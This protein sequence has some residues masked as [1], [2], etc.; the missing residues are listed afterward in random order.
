MTYLKLNLTYNQI[1]CGKTLLQNEK[2][3]INL[4]IKSGVEFNK[5][6]IYNAFG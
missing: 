6:N 2:P 3:L 5:L 1:K 4:N